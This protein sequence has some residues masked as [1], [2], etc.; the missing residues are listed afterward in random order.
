M[1]LRRAQGWV[2]AVRRTVLGVEKWVPWWEKEQ[3]AP[4]PTT[5]ERYRFGEWTLHATI[6][7]RG[8]SYY[9]VRRDGRARPV[10]VSVTWEPHY[11]W[12]IYDDDVAF[13]T[14]TSPLACLEWWAA[15][16]A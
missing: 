2:S 4:P 13:T 10:G 11:G 8:P 5:D 6:G 1:G 7:E 3:P 14:R 12:V 16:R 9:S 15:R